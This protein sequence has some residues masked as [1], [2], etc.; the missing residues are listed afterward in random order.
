MDLERAMFNYRFDKTGFFAGLVLIV[1]AAGTV[2]ATV[3]LLL[4]GDWQTYGPW[5]KFVWGLAWVLTII[6]VCVRV[7]IFSFLQQRLRR[8][9]PQAGQ[10][11]EVAAPPEPSGNGQEDGQTAG[12]RPASDPESHLAH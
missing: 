3:V 6:T 11:E 7:Q 10:R 2:I 1:I 8:Q 5:T 4:L 9:Q 12:P